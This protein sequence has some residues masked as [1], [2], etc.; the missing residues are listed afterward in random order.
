[1]LLHDPERA[2]LLEG[3]LL[4]R[5]LA[6]DRRDLALQAAHARLAGV[7]V[8]DPLDRAVGHRQVLGQEPVGLQLFRD[9]EILRDLDLLEFEIAREADDLHAV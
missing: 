8:D 6:A 2:R 3:R 4:A 5:D 1:M 7:G 9:Q